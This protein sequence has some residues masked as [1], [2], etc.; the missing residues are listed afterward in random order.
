MRDAIGIVVVCLG[1]V[2]ALIV[3]SVISAPS[4][5]EITP[6]ANKSGFSRADILSPESEVAIDLELLKLLT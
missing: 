6:I 1:A 5:N 4:E 3:C 2:L